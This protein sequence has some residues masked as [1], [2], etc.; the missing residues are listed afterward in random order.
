MFQ[1]ETWSTLE[2]S[3]FLFYLW[4]TGQARLTAAQ[5]QIKKKMLLAKLHCRPCKLA[6]SPYLGHGFSDNLYTVT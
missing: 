2:R 6:V 4:R 5:P 1:R 3:A